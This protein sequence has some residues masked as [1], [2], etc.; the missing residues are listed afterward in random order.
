MPQEEKKGDLIDVGEAD[1]KATEINAYWLKTTDIGE[2]TKI[3][4]KT[5]LRTLQDLSVIGLV[6]GRL[7]E[8]EKGTP[9]EWQVSEKT[10]KWIGSSEIFNDLD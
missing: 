7:T 2:G 9:Y 1:E 3:H 6:N 8:S 4:G 10:L 5:A